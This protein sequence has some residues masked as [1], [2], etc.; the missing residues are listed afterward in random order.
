MTAD[1][2]VVRVEAFRAGLE[3]RDQPCW[4]STPTSALRAARAELAHTDPDDPAIADFDAE[5]TY[6]TPDPVLGHAFHL[7]HRGPPAA[8]TCLRCDLELDGPAVTGRA[9]G[10]CPGRPRRYPW[11]QT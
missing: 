11:S 6:R 7:A 9:H 8:W 10:P 3:P 1:A 2:G 4:A 5:I